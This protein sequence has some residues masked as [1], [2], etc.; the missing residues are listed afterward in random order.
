VGTQFCAYAPQR[1]SAK[2]RRHMVRLGGLAYAAVAPQAFINVGY[3]TAANIA[4]MLETQ[5]PAWELRDLELY[6][7]PLRSEDGLA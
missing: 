3:T 5:T 6:E 4:L 7:L 2:I 1:T